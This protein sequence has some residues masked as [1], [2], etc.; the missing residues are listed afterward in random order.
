GIS[1]EEYGEQTAELWRKGLAQWGQDGARIERFRDSGDVAVYSPGSSAGGALTVLRSFAAPPAAL[2][3]QGEAYRERV[4][5][6]V[7]GLLALLGG[8][9]DPMSSREHILLASVL[10]N[11]WRAGRDLDMAGLI[12]AVQSPPFHK[13]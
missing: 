6:S 13:V 7:S 11:S 12:H 8:R 5:S 1:R 10:D 9:A 3:D 2:I 4:A